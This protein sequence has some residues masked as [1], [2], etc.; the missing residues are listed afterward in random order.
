MHRGFP[1]LSATAQLPDLDLRAEQLPGGA[2]LR[3]E[4]PP[5]ERVVMESQALL[6]ILKH[7]K[8]GAPRSTTGMVLGIQLG[9][10]VEV[11]NVIPQVQTNLYGTTMSEEERDFKD[12]EAEDKTLEYYRKAGW[13]TTVVGRYV[14]ASHA[15]WLAFRNLKY[16]EEQAVA[17]ETALLIAYDPQRTAMGK[18]FVRALVPT[19]AFFEFCAAKAQKQQR[20]ARGDAVEDD[21]TAATAAFDSELLAKG[22]IREVPISIYTSTA[23]KMVLAGLASK[24]RHVANRTVAL[25]SNAA[26]NELG[27]YTERTMHYLVE[28]L[29]KLRY[30]YL[31]GRASGIDGSQSSQLDAVLMSQQLEEQAVHLNAV[32]GGASMNLDFARA[33]LNYRTGGGAVAAPGPAAGGAKKSVTK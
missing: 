20:V 12:M 9:T 28:I 32:A 27:A 19:P 6:R 25:T 10:T 11:S 33:L 5:V 21:A 29:D 16:L 7:S 18:L 15:N 22:L 2:T 8:D 24:P 23:A 17:G 3:L 1:S 13:D 14:G 4:F 31:D 26:R 30:D